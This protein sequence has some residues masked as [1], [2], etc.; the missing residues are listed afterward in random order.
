M[1]KISGVVSVFPSRKSSVS[2][3]FKSGEMRFLYILVVEILSLDYEQIDE[4]K[5][6]SARYNDKCFLCAY[7]WES[8]RENR[9]AGLTVHSNYRMI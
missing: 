5:F 9:P 7:G 1:S 6:Y 2:L 4:P 3:K 8:C